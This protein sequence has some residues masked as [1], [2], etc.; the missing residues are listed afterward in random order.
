MLPSLKRILDARCAR[1]G[2]P[3]T[4]TLAIWL[5]FPSRDH[6]GVADQ[7]MIETRACRCGER[8]LVAEVDR[9]PIASLTIPPAEWAELRRRGRLRVD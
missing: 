9:Q 8:Y 2:H 1:R 7:V 3:T 4:T 6:Q 5:E